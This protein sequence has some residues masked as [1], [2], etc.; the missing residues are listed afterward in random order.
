MLV[1]L[2]NAVAGRLDELAK[3]YDE[4]HLRDALNIPGVAAARRY[5][6]ESVDGMPD[7][8]HALMAVYD[9]IGDPAA[10]WAE[11]ERRI[12]DGT[13]AMTDALDT[14]SMSFTM[15]ASCGEMPPAECSN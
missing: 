7:S 10:V 6:V 3:W 9:L 4:V 8:S 5:E 11:F 14:A 1:V 15:W 13:M 2:S 12:A